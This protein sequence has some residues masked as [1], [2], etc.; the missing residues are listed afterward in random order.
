MNPYHNQDYTRA[1]IDAILDEIHSCVSKGDFYISL[2]GRRQE[3]HGLIDEYNLRSEKQKSILLQITTDDFC[4]SLNNTKPGYEHEILYVFIPQVQLYNADGLE[5]T[6]DVYT[7]FNIIPR[8][9]GKYTVV[10]SFHKRNKP[11]DYLFR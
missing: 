11:A 5:E 7:K 3:N 1:D 6:V 10:V 2:K 9:S 8:S 4:H